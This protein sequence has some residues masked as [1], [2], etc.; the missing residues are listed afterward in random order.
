MCDKHRSISL[1]RHKYLPAIYNYWVF[2]SIQFLHEVRTYLS[3]YGESWKSA[4]SRYIIHD[5]MITAASFNLTTF[6]NNRNSFTNSLNIN[7][8][9]TTLNNSIGVLNLYSLNLK[10]I[11]F[12][13]DIE[14]A[15][16]NQ[17]LE[18]QNVNIN[19]IRQN[20]A[21]INKSID[22]LLFN[23]DSDVNLINVY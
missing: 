19:Q 3:R 10:N 11:S 8:A 1:H 9:N 16:Q 20:I 22:Q 17:L 15:I 13:N 12:S 18:L 5:V 2:E 4:F 23:A 6:I 14:V 7:I 21:Y